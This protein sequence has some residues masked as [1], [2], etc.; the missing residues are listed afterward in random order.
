[1]SGQDANMGNKR[2]NNS[3][4]SSIKNK[5]SSKSDKPKIPQRGLGVAQL[6]RLRHQM[7]YNCI[8][9][10]PHAPFPSLTLQD[11]MKVQEVNPPLMQTS[12]SFAYG[13]SQS[14]PF[15]YGYHPNTVMRFGDTE[16][17][18]LDMVQNPTQDETPTMERIITSNVNNMQP[19]QTWALGQSSTML[20]SQNSESSNDNQ[21]V[22]LELRLSI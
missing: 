2:S 6:E 10:A 16:S 14:L 12:A 15:C 1:M 20:S 13:Q 22:D 5:K 9:T 3:S 21:E 19:L 18:T 11:D 4:R 17:S 8:P 7:A